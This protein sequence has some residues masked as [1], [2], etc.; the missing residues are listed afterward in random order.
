MERLVDLGGHF[1]HA[2]KGLIV[3]VTCLI[4]GI[5]FND[6]CLLDLFLVFPFGLRG[7]ILAA[8][9]PEVTG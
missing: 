5:F 7:V 9:T 2:K 1:V 4:D 8:A 3:R 6:V